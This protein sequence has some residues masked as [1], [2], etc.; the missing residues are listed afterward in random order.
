MNKYK[1]TML[2]PI[3]NII[4]KEIY[5]LLS[6]RNIFLFFVSSRINT[7]FSAARVN[8][9][10]LINEYTKGFRDQDGLSSQAKYTI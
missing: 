1:E 2:K 7:S 10:V 8:N 9:S 4:K 6:A 5:S 3:G